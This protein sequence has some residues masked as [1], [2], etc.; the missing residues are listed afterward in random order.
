MPPLVYRDEAIQ[1]QRGDYATLL[2]NLGAASFQEV[3]EVFS[4]RERVDP[5]TGLTREVVERLRERIAR[6]ASGTDKK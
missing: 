1:K 6:Y 2:R 5:E 3:Q 4:E